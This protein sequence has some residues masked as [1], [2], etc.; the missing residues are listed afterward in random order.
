MLWRPFLVVIPSS[1]CGKT[2]QIIPLFI[3]FDAWV[4][5]FPIWVSGAEPARLSRVCPQCAD[6]TLYSVFTEAATHQRTARVLY[7]RACANPQHS[8]ALA[9]SPSQLL[10]RARSTQPDH[11]RT[12]R[13]PRAGYVVVRTDTTFDNYL[14][15]D[16][17]ANPHLAHPTKPSRSTA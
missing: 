4:R 15:W 13:F 16:A 12:H 9:I 2:P 7:A 3:I 17:G 5:L 1:E 11:A 14:L 6:W 8:L 10:P